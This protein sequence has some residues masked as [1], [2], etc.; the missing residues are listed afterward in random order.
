[1]TD[2]TENDSSNP[3]VPEKAKRRR[4]EAFSIVFPEK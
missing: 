1:M 2:G 4:F 3:E